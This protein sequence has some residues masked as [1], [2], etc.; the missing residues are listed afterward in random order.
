M[1]FREEFNWV[2]LTLNE[3]VSCEKR[4]YS[5]KHSLIKICRLIGP[6]QVGP[7][8]KKLFLFAYTASNN[9]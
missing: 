5:W 6:A 9:I 2:Q 4:E 7:K 8:R 1:S 3:V